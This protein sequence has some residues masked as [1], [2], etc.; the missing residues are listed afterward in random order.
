LAYTEKFIFA[1]KELAKK[2][3]IS[4]DSQDGIY[5]GPSERISLN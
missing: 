2:F 3:A 5:Q 1:Y 4:I